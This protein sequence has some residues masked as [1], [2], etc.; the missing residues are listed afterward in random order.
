MSS[1]SEKVLP[2][3]YPG[4][5]TEQLAVVYSVFGFVMVFSAG[6]GHSTRAAGCRRK[7][8]TPS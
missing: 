8:L 4:S 7:N 1:M 5:A 6:G 3:D 2:R